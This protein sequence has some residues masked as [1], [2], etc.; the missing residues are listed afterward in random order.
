MTTS[1]I[2]KFNYI[3]GNF[4][5]CTVYKIYWSKILLDLTDTRN[6]CKKNRSKL[7]CKAGNMTNPTVEWFQLT[8]TY[9]DVKL[10]T[11]TNLDII[12]LNR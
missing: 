7:I 5:T 9:D 3:Y 11:I 8:H 1:N 6:I 4:N 2:K 10:M 12:C